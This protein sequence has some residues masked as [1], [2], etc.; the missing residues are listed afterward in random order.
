ME[1]LTS[2]VFI[3]YPFDKCYKPLLHALVFTIIRCGFQPRCA[4]EIHDAA[5]T[6]IQKISRIISGCRYGIHDISRTELD[7]KTHLPRFNMPLEL[8]L[9]LGSIYFGPA[10]GKKYCL[11]LDK[12]RYRYQKF[13]SDISG[14][15][16]ESHEDQPKSMVEVVREFLNSHFQD[17][18]L[19]AGQIIFKEYDIFRENLPEIC[20]SE[21][22]G[23]PEDLSYLDF[24]YIASEWIS[25]SP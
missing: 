5:E 14:Q 17:R 20:E 7:D 25:K 23:E 12:E 22:L 8:G 10:D 2:H 19:P 15:D 6:R 16:I 3:N 4:A 24:L 9:F 18:P 21:N 11:I 13:I 1:I